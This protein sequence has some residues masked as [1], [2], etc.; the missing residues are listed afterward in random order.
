MTPTAV[1]LILIALTFLGLTFRDIVGYAHD[2]R[3]R[4][5]P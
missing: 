4:S 1:L 2:Y 3:R 5:A